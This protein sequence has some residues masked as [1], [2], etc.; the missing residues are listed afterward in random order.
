MDVFWDKGYAATS[1]DDLTQ[2]MEI[3]RPSLYAAFGDKHALY[4]KALAAYRARS[5]Q[6]T[7]AVLSDTKT[8]RLAL[9]DFYA[10]ALALYLTGKKGARGCFTIGTALVEAIADPEIRATLA[11]GIA[12]LDSTMEKR[13]ALAQKKGEI[14]KSA[15]PALLA[16]LASA[17]LYTLAIRARAGQPKAELQK[18]ID[19]GV[20]AICGA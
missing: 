13:I 2:A 8:L 19:A 6:Q 16:K 12:Q 9:S 18:M 5:A 14:A 3:N 11:E 20:E 17:T 15:N 10:G 4:Q 7:A 1:L